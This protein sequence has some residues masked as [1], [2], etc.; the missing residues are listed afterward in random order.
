MAANDFNP[1]GTFLQVRSVAVNPTTGQSIPP[2]GTLAYQL[3]TNQTLAAGSSSTPVTSIMAGSYI[4]N[5]TGASGIAGGNALVLESLGSDGATYQTV[6]TA[7]AA[8]NIGVVLG[9][10]S[11]VRI[12]NSGASQITG[13]YSNLS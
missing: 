5:V 6:T 3:A 4:W 2:S 10:N 12:R 1:S 7:T 9:A 11:T 8:G 13:I